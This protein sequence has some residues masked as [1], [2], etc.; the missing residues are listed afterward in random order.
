MTQKIAR[1]L[2]R[3][4]SATLLGQLDHTTV[5]IVGGIYWDCGR[6]RLRT[7]NDRLVSFGKGSRHQVSLFLGGL[8]G[9]QHVSIAHI[10]IL[11]INMY[12]YLLCIELHI[13]Y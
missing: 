11:C 4:M 5:T 12:I 10:Y 3:A 2:F 7:M 8:L 9:D 1:V 13:M 6:I